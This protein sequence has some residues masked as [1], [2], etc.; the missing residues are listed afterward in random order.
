[1]TLT[2]VE[3]RRVRIDCGDGDWIE[4]RAPIKNGDEIYAQN[5]ASVGRGTKQ[6]ME[7]QFLAGAYKLALMER[8][9]VAWSDQTPITAAA[10]ETLPQHVADRVMA[11]IN[12]QGELRGEAATAPLGS[13]SN[14]PSA[15]PEDGGQAS[16][17]MEAG[18]ESLDT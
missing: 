18:Q 17:S 3:E 7:V 16:P 1:M 13:N 11:E 6:G 12:R 10:I 14:S 4:I 8:L 2:Q 9:I 15:S 5:R